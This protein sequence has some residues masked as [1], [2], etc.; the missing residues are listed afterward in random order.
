MANQSKSLSIIA[1][2]ICTALYAVGSYATAYIPSPWG[3]GQFRPA[4]V[5]PA[6]FAV[7]FGPLPAGIGAAIGT[8]IADSVK[9]GTL[10]FG[11]LFAAVPGN[12][13]GFY[14]FGRI[15][16]KFSWKRF[17]I[18]ANVTL[19]SANFITAFL[20]IYLYRYLFLQALK[21]GFMDIMLLSV[22]LTIWW[23]ITML[24]FVLIFDPLL[25]KAASAAIPSIVPEDV[26]YKSFSEEY[27]N[28]IFG[29]SLLAPGL[30]LLVLG[31]IITFTDF[32]RLMVSI[33][34]LPT[35]VPLQTLLYSSGVVLVPLGVLS[36]SRAKSKSR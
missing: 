4:V 15:C 22:G 2:T 35:I 7:L 36:L 29:L 26:R 16:R 28:T 10:H 32:G 33:T 17:I 5:I 30:I 23:Y 34:K 20:Y 21:V 8:L 27:S 9:H 18:A 24:P 19:T 14:I 31:L 3:F 11:S 25:I 13:V 1:T 12:F 6:F